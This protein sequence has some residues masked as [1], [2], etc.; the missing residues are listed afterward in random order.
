MSVPVAARTASIS[1][2]FASRFMRS[3][4]RMKRE[5]PGVPSG[6]DAEALRASDARRAER[7]DVLKIR[8]RGSVFSTNAAPIF[9]D[10]TSTPRDFNETI[11]DATV[12]TASNIGAPVAATEEM[13]PENWTVG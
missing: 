13:D 10:G 3:T 5:A 8:I 9:T 7:T 2:S 12:T 11:G 1:A 4:Q 6:V